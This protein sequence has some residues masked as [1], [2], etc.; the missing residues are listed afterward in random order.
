MYF[1]NLI[2]IPN[3]VTSIGN[4]AFFRCRSLTSVTIPNSVT[5]IEEYVFYGCTSLDTVICLGN[6]PADV[7]TDAFNNSQNNMTLIVPCGKSVVY[8]ASPVWKWFG[9]IVENCEQSSIDDVAENTTV[10]LYPNPTDKNTTL[11]IKGLNEQV[12]IIVTNQQGQIITTTT[13]TKGREDLE[14]ETSNLPSG[15]YYIRIQTDK[16]VKTEKLIKK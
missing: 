12:D 4:Y 10:S 7:Q 8:Q 6:I 9:N 16:F 14:I 5:S 3:S 13:L 11:N 1:F 15:I 2:T